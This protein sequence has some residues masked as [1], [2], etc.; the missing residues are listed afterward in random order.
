MVFW[1]VH[2]W[3]I[4]RPP[5]VIHASS[6]SPCLLPGG[7][8]VCHSPSVAD[9]DPSIP[10]NPRGRVCSGAQVEQNLST[11]MAQLYRLH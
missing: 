9:L 8:P 10:F 1:Q 3:L 5:G 11:V 7:P 2:I 4:Q 6:G